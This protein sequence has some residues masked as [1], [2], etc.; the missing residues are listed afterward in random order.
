MKYN[1][2]ENSFVQKEVLGRSKSCSIIT[3]KSIRIY[4]F[5]FLNSFEH[6]ARLDSRCIMLITCGNVRVTRQFRR[7][8][9]KEFFMHPASD[10]EKK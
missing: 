5:E 9:T 7:I 2:H 6:F 1:R 4:L 3:K 10:H 8:S